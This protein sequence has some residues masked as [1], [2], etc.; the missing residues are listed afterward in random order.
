[1]NTRFFYT[2]NHSNKGTKMKFLKIKIFIFLFLLTSVVHAKEKM[3]WMVIHWP[4]IMMLDG[5]DKGKGKGDALLEMFIENMTQYQHVKKKMNWAR[6]WKNIREGQPICNFMALK[7]PAREKFAVFSIPLSITT[8]YRIVMTQK[9]WERL[10]KVESYSLAKLMGN[11]KFKG[12]IEKKRS[13]KKL[14]KVVE[15]NAEGSG[16]RLGAA[17]S[18]N[19]FNMMFLD[20]V[21]YTIEYPYVASYLD[22]LIGG[23]SGKLRYIEIEESNA[24]GFGGHVACPKN[25][26]GRK[27]IVN[28]DKVIR[29]EIKTGSLLKA[30]QV[31]QTDPK[32]RE[33]IEKFFNENFLTL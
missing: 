9:A 14:N 23:S 33:M 8:P 17:K 29:N 1:M 26:W 13:Y 31:W 11:Q 10:G 5:A 15:D 2:C 20:R 19:I 24:F 12:R 3:T 32:D 25:D 30:L 4:P 18:K 6:V 27:V 7:N 28:I 16:L 22:K 21:D